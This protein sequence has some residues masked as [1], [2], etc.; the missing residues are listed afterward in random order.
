MKQ[1][2]VV[3]CIQART[4]SSRLPGKVMLP[5][6]GIPLSVLAA[7]R[8]AYNASYEVRV[9]TSE[10][11]SD[12]HLASILCD[13][14]VRCYR[15]SLDNVLQRFVEALS[16]LSEDTIIV[17]LTADNVFPDASFI[18]ELVSQYT[19]NCLEYIC[20]NGE[21]S[22]LPYGLSAEV[23][24]LRYLREALRNTSELFDLEHVTPYI[25]RKYGDNH[26]RTELSSDEFVHLRCTIDNLDD[27]LQVLKVFKSCDDAVSVTSRELTK[28]L[29]EISCC[30]G[31][32][33]SL[34]LGGAQLGLSYGINNST[35][36][37]SSTEVIDILS[38]A[39]RAGVEFIDTARVYG[40]SEELIGSWLKSGWQGRCQIITK[41][42]HLKESTEE[43]VVLEVENSILKS[44]LSLG[45]KTLD[46][47]M[48]HR[49]DHLT[50]HSGAVFRKLQSLKA[51][52]R[53]KNIGVSVQ[54]P[55]EIELALRT[56]DVSFIQLPYNILDHRWDYLVPAIRKAKTSR[57][58]TIHARSVLLQGLLVSEDL[59]LWEKANLKESKVIIEWLKKESQEQGFATISELCI[60]YVRNVDWIDG[61]VLGCET[62]RQL[63]ENIKT[64]NMHHTPNNIVQL[65]EIKPPFELD[66]STLNPVYWR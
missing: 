10:E 65:K 25:R 26:A 29:V 33:N 45:M 47:L 7:Q 58:L 41:L 48:L 40:N 56:E 22:Q 36:Q 62:E 52:G 30:K 39:A 9:L 27:Y 57:S 15:G 31:K 20:A 6:S 44:S 13:Y 38:Y 63:S 1:E 35:G 11:A 28:K 51:D 23:T 8:A 32:S 21:K 42:D 59:K 19:E 66:E 12:D 2:N 61:V 60:S 64:I 54:T 50:S 55:Q 49:A 18:N 24:R 34:V 46:V 16:D 3:V 17:R 5:I 14:G 43:N 4:N 37:P 53:I